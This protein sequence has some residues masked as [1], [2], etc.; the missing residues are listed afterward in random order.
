MGA[1][2]LELEATLRAA[3]KRWAVTGAAGF[4]GSTLVRALLRLDQHVV[5]VDDLSTGHLRNLPE[6]FPLIE[7]DIRD[8]AAC[9]TAVAGADFVL[10]HAALGS[11]PWSMQDPLRTHA[12]NVTGF[13]NVLMAA[14]EAD[15]A[16]VVYAASSASYG[17]C[18]TVP[19][20][21]DRLG[22]PLSPY[23]ASKT[24]NEA[25]AGAFAEGYGL[26]AVGLR[27]FNVFGARQDPEGP[28]AAVIPR[29]IATLLEGAPVVINGD[30]E[31]TRD[32]CHVDNVVAANLLA[33]LA[34]LPAPHRVYNI[35]CGEEISLNRLLREIR[36]VLAERGVETPAAPHYGPFREGDVRRSCADIGRA[37]AEL[38][39]R[40]E[41]GLR[42]GLARAMDWY[43]AEAGVDLTRRS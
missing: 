39:Y 42:D 36:A 5:G 43:C 7:G 37:V 11:V 34:T 27:Y 25:Y 32:F 16:R 22:D 38:G 35:A 21:E 1:I 17:T 15:C 9:A 20:V 14:R 28:Y 41:M 18:G 3:P 26:S 33:A 2:G 30:G 12:V 29:W 10:H 31:T 23:A 19:A 8:P 13:L 24:A 4:I 40:P 6:G